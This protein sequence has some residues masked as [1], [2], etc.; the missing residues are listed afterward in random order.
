MAIELFEPEQLW[1]WV[2]RRRVRP[3]WV[4][5]PVAVAVVGGLVV[6]AATEIGVR[7]FNTD[8]YSVAGYTAQPERG[9]G[10]LLALWLSA[11]ALP[12]AQGLIG[13][14]LLP[15]YGRRRDWA[16]G[17]AVGVFGS[18]PIYAVAPALAVLPG[19]LLVVVAFLVS[20]AWWSSGARSLLGVPIGESADYV[21]A[22]IIAASLALSFALGVVPYA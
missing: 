11:T 18:L 21:V 6:A 5:T 2:A 9:W 20:C 16:G 8:W 17:L 4:W 10:P 22:S 14:G 13:G 1:Q 7:L 15:L 19:I 3:G 12:L